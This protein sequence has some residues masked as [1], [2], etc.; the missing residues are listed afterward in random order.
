LTKGWLCF[1]REGERRR[2]Q[3]IPERWAA[4]DDAGLEKLL[5]VANVAPVR[6]RTTADRSKK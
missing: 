1:E 2:L 5:E 4:L 3:P 6:K